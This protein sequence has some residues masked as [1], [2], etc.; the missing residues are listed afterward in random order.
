[1][2]TPLVRVLKFSV[3]DMLRNASLATMTVVVLSLLLISI[4]TVLGIRFLA[5][6]AV[7]SVKDKIDLSIYLK[8][9]V[10]P[11]TVTAL[12]EAIKTIKITKK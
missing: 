9:T 7:V 1:M 3:Q 4:N 11:E 5:N 8:P 6:Q 12:D 2:L 10:R